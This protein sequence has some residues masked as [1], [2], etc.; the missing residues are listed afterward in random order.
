VAISPP[1]R[2]EAEASHYIPYLLIAD[3]WPLRCS[4]TLEA[5]PR[6]ESGVVPPPAGTRLKP[7]TTFLICW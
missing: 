3:R 1:H 4:A 5:L 6:P 2:H 7:R